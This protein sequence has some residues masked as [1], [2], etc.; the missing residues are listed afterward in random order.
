MDRI[1]RKQKTN[2]QG[3]FVDFKG[4]CPVHPMASHAWGDCFNNPKIKTSESQYNNNRNQDRQYGCSYN[5]STR[6]CGNGYG[7][8]H[9]NRNL[10][11]I[12]NP[13]PSLYIEQA[14]ENNVPDTLSTVTNTDNFTVA[15]H[16]TYVIKTISNKRGEKNS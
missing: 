5:Y 13:Y 14:P 7:R 3:P 15:P 9:N 12:T 8:G 2:N 10:P 6:G 16:Q 4:P 1:P 11:Q